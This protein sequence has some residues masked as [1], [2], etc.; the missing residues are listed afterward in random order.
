MDHKFIFDWPGMKYNPRDTMVYKWLPSL[1][2]NQED[3]Y[4]PG[5][6]IDR[7][8]GH[9]EK[10]RFW[11]NYAMNK[12]TVSNQNNFYWSYLNV[13]KPVHFLRHSK[14]KLWGFNQPGLQELGMEIEKTWSRAYLKSPYHISKAGFYMQPMVDTLRTNLFDPGKLAVLYLK[15]K[16]DNKLI[17]IESEI[18]SSMDPYSDWSF[19]R[20]TLISSVE[21]SALFSE[22]NLLNKFTG[23]TYGGYRGRV[24]AGKIWTNKSGVPNQE[25]YNIEGNSSAEMFRVSYLRSQDS[26][27]GLSEINNNYHMAGEGN[28]RGLVSQN[29]KGADAGGSV[30]GEIFL[31]NKRVDVKGY[32]EDRPISLELAFFADGGIF[33]NSGTIR[34]LGDAGI[35]IRISSTVYDKPLYLRLDFPFILFKDGENLENDT[36]WV[37]SFQRSI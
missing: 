26:F 33:Y 37:I 22:D 27:F 35:G 5:L 28:I 24:F 16:I 15:Y 17:D 7:T 1:Y 2:Y 8:Y 32:L 25:A 36:K 11:F 34:K 30:T 20:I 6:R 31:V 13:H 18:S 12:D 14:L 4:T 3:G 29:E 9:W 23:F 21:S 19:N 10:K